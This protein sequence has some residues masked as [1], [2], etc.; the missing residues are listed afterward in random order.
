MTMAGAAAR[1]I[2]PPNPLD[3]GSDQLTMIAFSIC[4]VIGR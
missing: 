2:I 1:F 4:L 3:A